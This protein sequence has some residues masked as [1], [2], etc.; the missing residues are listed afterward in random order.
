MP[1]LPALLRAPLPKF[2]PAPAINARQM[3]ANNRFW[4]E[5][6]N[7]VTRRYGGRRRQHWGALLLMLRTFQWGLGRLGPLRRGRRNAANIVL[8]EREL[9]FPELARAFDGFFI[10]H[11][12]DPRFDGLP[13]IDERIIAL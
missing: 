7:L 10:L 3:W 9:S 2:A 5:T 8:R 12:S 13:G 4:M 11:L 6:Q 1:E